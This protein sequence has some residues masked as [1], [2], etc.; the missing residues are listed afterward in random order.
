ME[1]RTTLPP[2]ESEAGASDVSPPNTNGLSTTLPQDL[3]PSAAPQISPATPPG[4]VVK[5]D[6]DD[7]AEKKLQASTPTLEPSEPNKSDT[8]RATRVSETISHA[9]F[10]ETSRLDASGARPDVLTNVQTTTVNKKSSQISRSKEPQPSETDLAAQVSGT[11][12]YARSFGVSSAREDGSSGTTKTAPRALRPSKQN[13]ADADPSAQV[14]GTV[15]KPSLLARAGLDLEATLASSNHTPMAPRP[16]LKVVEEIQAKSGGQVEGGAAQR[17]SI[18]PDPIE[19]ELP[20]PSFS[21]KVSILT[22]S[23][24]QPIY[25]IGLLPNLGQKALDV[26]TSTAIVTVAPPTLVALR[27]ILRKATETKKVTQNKVVTFSEDVQVRDLPMSEEDRDARLSLM[28]SRKKR[29][30]VRKSEIKEE[31]QP[32][33]ESE[34]DWEPTPT[35]APVIAQGPG[36]DAAAQGLSIVQ[37]PP[38]LEEC[39]GVTA[40][41]LSGAA[42]ISQVQSWPAS[43]L[44]WTNLGGFQATAMEQPQ[45]PIPMDVDVEMLP[46]SLPQ[47]S[48]QASD[49][50]AKRDWLSQ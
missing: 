49:A 37:Q 25:P 36:N 7:T 45:D 43:G 18:P 47:P 35:P 50:P 8:D 33:G 12:S 39:Q 40:N 30:G 20:N 1:R 17:Q 26:P 44:G 46:Y 22:T 10:L 24:P 21:S 19:K 6:S 9:K 2:L 48:L 34:M 27:P 4:I 29:N 11:V 23:T 15:S 3:L 41:S 42:G 14:S 31:K 16:H 5:I 28:P 32:E 13:T 38:S